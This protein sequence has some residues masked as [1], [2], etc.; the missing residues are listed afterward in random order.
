MIPRAFF[1]LTVG[2]MLIIQSVYGQMADSTALKVLTLNVWSGLDYEG[3]FHMGEYESA[4]HRRN[5]KQILL[6]KLRESAPDVI[7]LQEVN[8]V[9]AYARSLADQLGYQ[10]YSRVA[11]G[12][13]R[14]GPVGIPVNFR[15]GDAI[16]VRDGIEMRPLGREKLVGAGISTNYFTFHFGEITQVIGV[17]IRMGGERIQ[18]FNTHL[19][20]GPGTTD[21]VLDHVRDRWKAGEITADPFADILERFHS[22]QERRREEL[23]HALNFI[24]E[25]GEPG[26]LTLFAGDFNLTPEE[27]TYRQI[28]DAGF[29]DAYL[30]GNDHPPNTWDPQENSNI[31]SYYKAPEE[32]QGPL[33]AI[34][35]EMDHTARRID[36]IFFKDV[37]KQITGVEISLFGTTPADGIHISDH[38]GLLTEIS[39]K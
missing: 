13:I 18:V 11:M 8:P 31:Q 6:R 36:Y 21:D 34:R 4:E 22:H 19:H 37:N 35:W 3:V 10:N 20:A 27:K 32:F 26:L 14:F 38:F 24:K 1:L 33:A 39:F 15:E 29:Q 28:T 23:H 16:L 5:R 25:T 2:V 12:G 7:C 30:R 17:E 9:P